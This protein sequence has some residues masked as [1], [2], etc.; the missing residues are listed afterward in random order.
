MRKIVICDDLEEERERL[1]TA[2]KTCLA[3][4]GEEAEI[5]EYGSGIPLLSDVQEGIIDMDLL[6]LDIFMQ[7]S[8][9]ME[10]AK[11]LRALSCRVP[12]IF[13]TTSPDFA[14]E[15]Y[16]VEACAYLVKPLSEEKLMTALRRALKSVPRRRI[17]VRS[18]GQYRYVY[19]S[20]ILYAESERHW[21]T[22]YMA[23]GS[24]VKTLEKLGNIEEQIGEPCFLR[25]H[26][27]YLVNMD[28][29]EDVQ[30]GFLMS[31]GI[32]VPIRVRGRKE[33]LDAY[34]NYFMRS[35]R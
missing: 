9:G 35:A 11:R 32:T 26:Q 2:V 21:V 16:D 4:L 12:I 25:C 29:I 20:D 33:A 3:K 13:L 31:N 5:T 27:S 34:Y 15:S 30:E 19:I 7:G 18:G 14:V 24:E 1:K 8:N 17:A 6:F 23:D 22:L 28:R 10:T